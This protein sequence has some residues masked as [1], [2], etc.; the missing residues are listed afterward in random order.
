MQDLFTTLWGVVDWI[1]LEY[2]VEIFV[3]FLVIY[4][5]LRFM[6]GTRGEES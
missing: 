4:A 1:S 2:F 5:F 6:E 3:I